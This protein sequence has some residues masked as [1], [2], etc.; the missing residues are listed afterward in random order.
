MLTCARSA[1][2]ALDFLQVQSEEKVQWIFLI[3]SVY[4][5]TCDIWC[6]GWGGCWDTRYVLEIKSP[7]GLSWSPFLKTQ[8]HAHTQV[9]F[10]K[11]IHCLLSLPLFYPPP[12]HTYTS[13]SC[14]YSRLSWIAWKSIC[15]TTTI[16]PPGQQSPNSQPLLHMQKKE[17]KSL[18]SSIQPSLQPFFLCCGSLPSWLV[19]S[20]CPRRP[21]SG[22]CRRR[23]WRRSFC[24]KRRSREACHAPS[25]THPMAHSCRGRKSH[26][27]WSR[28]AWRRSRRISKLHIAHAY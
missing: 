14:K 6:S 3:L 19:R 10:Q 13:S 24:Q 11:Y 1:P 21:A 5:C 28:A 20:L 2:R 12:T 23:Q 4:K 25:Q 16:L 8:T 17:I 22:S 27:Q 7:Q 26:H 9:P 15:P 18:P